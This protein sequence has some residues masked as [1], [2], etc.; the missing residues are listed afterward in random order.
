MTKTDIQRC[1]IIA[2]L[3]SMFSL[4]IHDFMITHRVG[5]D[6]YLVFLSEFLGVMGFCM[7]ALLN[8]A[9]VDFFM[10]EFRKAIKVDYRRARR[11]VRRMVLKF[12]KWKSN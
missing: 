12:M 3:M 9:T 5:E 8:A 10:P 7:I 1:W 6:S 11:S 2:L 4:Q